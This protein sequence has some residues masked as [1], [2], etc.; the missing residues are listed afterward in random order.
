MS[1][2]SRKNKS[3]SVNSD[4]FIDFGVSGG[5]RQQ[6]KRSPEEFRVP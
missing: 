4:H 3:P 5:F 1:D 2:S 6:F